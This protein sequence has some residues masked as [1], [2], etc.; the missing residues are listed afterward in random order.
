M[1][2]QEKISAYE[3]RCK[4]LEEV[5]KQKTELVV[6]SAKAKKELQ[7]ELEAVQKEK[8]EYE[9]KCNKLEVELKE[10]GRKSFHFQVKIGNKIK[11]EGNSILVL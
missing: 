3:E 7:Y 11:Q 9:G 5:N 1:A 8:L 10:M 4:E 6:Y 2:L